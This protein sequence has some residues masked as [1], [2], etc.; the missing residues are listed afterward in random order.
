MAPAY[1]RPSVTKNGSLVSDMSEVPEDAFK[2]KTRVDASTGQTTEYWQL[3]YKIMVTIQ[4]GPMLFS[5][6]CNGKEY[7]QAEAQY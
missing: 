5:L 7:G 4:S 1:P 2:K 3:H 6:M